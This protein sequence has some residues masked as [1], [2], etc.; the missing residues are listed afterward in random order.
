MSTDIVSLYRILPNVCRTALET[1]SDETQQNGIIEN[2][3][4]DETRPLPSTTALHRSATLN[5]T[6]T[7]GGIARG[8][9][10]GH[11]YT[12]EFRTPDIER[13]RP[14][15]SEIRG[16]RGSSAAPVEMRNGGDVDSYTN[17][18]NLETGVNQTRAT[19]R[20]QSVVSRDGDHIVHDD[21]CQSRSM[22]VRYT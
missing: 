5:R 4:S 22:D 18:D 12:V 14:E 21:R 19:S 9:P 6:S 20:R 13:G 16:R 10:L 2:E 17:L 7:Q 11:T 8:V 3:S 1:S 15:R